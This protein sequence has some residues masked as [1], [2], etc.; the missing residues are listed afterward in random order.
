MSILERRT[1]IIT[2]S[3]NTNQPDGSDTY[4]CFVLH[5]SLTWMIVN[6]VT[7]A[8]L[9]LWLKE[10]PLLET[11]TLRWLC[12]SQVAFF[13]EAS[14]GSTGSHPVQPQW[15]SLSLTLKHTHRLLTTDQ[16]THNYTDTDTHSVKH[17]CTHTSSHTPSE[18][19]RHDR[20]RG[21]GPHAG[22]ALTHRSLLLGPQ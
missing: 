18:P 2:I 4:L 1:L 14:T 5:G 16:Y 17:S 21:L 7:Y 20:V 22:E 9:S 13:S 6:M 11:K 10:V 3:G 19:K 15:I 8:L 12:W